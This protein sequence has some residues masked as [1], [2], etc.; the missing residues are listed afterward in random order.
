M[1]SQPSNQPLPDGG[2]RVEH[3]AQVRASS[4][5]WALF[6]VTKYSTFEALCAYTGRLFR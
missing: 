3:G 2:I 1:H 6:H 4:P 5:A